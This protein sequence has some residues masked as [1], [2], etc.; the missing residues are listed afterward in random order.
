MRGRVAERSPNPP[1]RPA[2]LGCV[3]RARAAL[4]D[5]PRRR[6][7]GARARVPARGAAA[8]HGAGRPRRDGVRRTAGRAARRAVAV[9]APR[10]AV[11]RDRAAGLVRPAG[12][13]RVGALSLTAPI[14]AAGG[15]LGVPLAAVVG[16]A[17]A[18]LLRGARDA[19][20]AGARRRRT[21]ARRPSFAS[22]RGVRAAG[23]APAG[24]TPRFAIWPPGRLRGRWST[25]TS[26]PS[27][28]QEVRT[29]WDATSASDCSSERSW[30][31]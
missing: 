5:R 27:R 8:A 15:W 4:H 12:G 26:P 14:F 20:V 22:R 21:P 30:S 25:S 31:S 19:V 17:V 7:R 2:Q 16:L 1:R 6:R 18:L 13:R 11:V 24:S 29:R 3:G 28:T 10:L 9:A 23:R